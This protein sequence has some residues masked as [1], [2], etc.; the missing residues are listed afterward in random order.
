MEQFSDKMV[1]ISWQLKIVVKLQEIIQIFKCSM[2]ELKV[3]NNLN[4][5]F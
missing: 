3:T 5:A 4:T 1:A 2:S